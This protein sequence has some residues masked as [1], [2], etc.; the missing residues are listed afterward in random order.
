MGNIDLG[1]GHRLDLG[2]VTSRVVLVVAPT[3]AFR[4]VPVPGIVILGMGLPL[5]VLGF[6]YATSEMP[7]FPAVE[8]LL[9]GVLA[10]SVLWS[11][12]A[13][14]STERLR[15][16][17]PLLLATVAAANQVSAATALRC[18]KTSF[19]VMM[20][21]SALRV[22][23]FPAEALRAGS[24]DTVT[25][26]FSKNTFGGLLVLSLVLLL[27]TKRRFQPSPGSVADRLAGP[28]P[29]GHRVVRGGLPGRCWLLQSLGDR[30]PAPHHRSP[31][32]GV[33]D[34][35]GSGWGDFWPPKSTW[36]PLCPRSARI[37]HWVG[38]LTSGRPAGIR[39]RTHPCW[40]TVRSPFWI[41]HRSSPV[42]LYVW[43]QFEGYRPPHPH[44]GLLDLAGQL[45]LL[46]VLVFALLMGT[47]MRAGATE[48]V[49]GDKVSLTA[50]LVLSFIVLFGA[51]EVTYLGPWLVV[52]FVAC[53]AIRPSREAP[54]S[55][56]GQRAPA[57]MAVPTDLRSAAT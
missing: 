11:D 52:T 7:R 39:Y 21:L 55:T 45:G 10:S 40:A 2:G 49:R 51:T 15:T 36:M 56:A 20:T 34:V 6:T 50:V 47:S 13:G 31:R 4:A 41:R 24:V 12:G 43:S 14:Y 18:L 1:A 46:G 29:V 22:L 23:L 32:P 42:T 30:H 54:R 16:Y 33:H 26:G 9:V 8:L 35:G 38:A 27:D 3:I 19:V 25:A 5:L 28:Q 37:R 53:A 48:A 44:N 57:T 17:L